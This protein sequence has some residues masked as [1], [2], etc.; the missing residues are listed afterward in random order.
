M[1]KV[2]E[3]ENKINF[4]IVSILYYILNFISINIIS[5]CT[6]IMLKPIVGCIPY[7]E[8]YVKMVKVP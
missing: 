6:D 8:G 4:L 1:K 7:Y 2:S 3:T 5:V